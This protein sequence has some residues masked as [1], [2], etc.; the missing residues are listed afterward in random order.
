MK[1]I[2]FSMCFLAVCFFSTYS[3][4]QSPSYTINGKLENISPMPVKM[5]L[6]EIIS[7][8]MLEKAIDS[9]NVVNGQYQFKGQL[10]VDEAIFVSIRISKKQSG[11]TNNI[12]VILDKGEL[13]LVSMGT[14][15]NFTASGSAA[16]AQHQFEDM[17]NGTRQETDAIN[18]LAASE[19]Y[20]T[21]KELQAEVRKR[22]LGMI[23]KT[24]FEMYSYVKN[25][26]NNRISPYSTFFLISIPY[27][28]QT[29][30]DTLIHILAASVKADK[31][32]AAIMNTY[33]RSKTKSDSIMKVALSKHE[34]NMSKVAIGSKAQDFTQND[35]GEKPVSLSSFKGKYV[36]VD[37]WASWC[38]PCR[39]ENPNV[40][41]A[42][43]KYKDKG[44]TVL[45]VSLDS[46]SAR[47]AWLKAIKSDGLVWTQVSDLRGFKNEAAI[48]YDIKAIPQNFLIDPNGVVIGKDLRGD[49]L[50]A[51]LAAIFK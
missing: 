2:F 15:G 36:L 33:T 43:N 42:Y 35:P 6:S 10:T 16:K 5:Y 7:A 46:Q 24:V 21:N 19:D 39:A 34:A 20:K 51:K 48:M 50:D 30:K 3:F 45:G 14:L 41:K 40:V 44:F 37:F 8:G 28:D 23:G 26:P 49:G 27:L 12:P 31:L 11:G 17:R 25:N 22:S 47:A 13:N 9:A 32:G 1:R 29:G 4:A 38:G 18:K